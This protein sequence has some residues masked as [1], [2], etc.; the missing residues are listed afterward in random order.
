LIWRVSHSVA[1]ASC[2]SSVRESLAR[3]SL[4]TRGIALVKAV[5]HALSMAS[6]CRLICGAGEGGGQGRQVRRE[7]AA[8]ARACGW[9][10]KTPAGKAGE[11]R[12]GAGATA[13]HALRPT[14]HRL[15]QRL[16]LCPR[17]RRLHARHELA[18][19]LGVLDAKQLQLVQLQLM[20]ALCVYHGRSA[21]RWTGGARAC[22]AR[23]GGRR[24]LRVQPPRLQACAQAGNA[25]PHSGSACPTAHLQ[26]HGIRSRCSTACTSSPPRPRTRTCSVCKTAGGRRRP[27]RCCCPTVSTRPLLLHAPLSAAPLG[28]TAFLLLLPDRFHAPAATP[29]PTPRSACIA[30]G[31]ANAALGQGWPGAPG[32]RGWCQP[33]ARV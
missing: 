11:G 24:P 19:L 10:A 4:T 6:G 29:A 32:P 17:P 15:Q 30:A 13:P 5:R 2:A 27:S 26:Q 14:T 8:R 16:Q 9:R 22:R 33:A 3:W 21:P 25:M 7:M 20:Q 31:A 12:A 23:V 28:T 1:V 18:Q